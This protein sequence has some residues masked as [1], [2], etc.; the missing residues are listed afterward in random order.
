MST[1]ICTTPRTGST[2]LASLLGFSQPCELLRVGV[3]R[4]LPRLGYPFGKPLEI[5]RHASRHG[6]KV[7]W[8]QV[9]ALNDMVR[10]SAT[11]EECLPEDARYVFLTRGDVSSQ[12]RSLLTAERSGD[13]QTPFV[14]YADLDDQAVA[15]RA[16]WIEKQNCGWNGW[17][18]ARHIDPVR[19]TYEE[20]VAGRTL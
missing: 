14:P 11:L 19:V 5:R 16:G 9:L 8:D 10:P 17:F 3:R 7:L 6:I 4:E 13:W 20:L 12:A 18:A 2:W 15:H 1:V